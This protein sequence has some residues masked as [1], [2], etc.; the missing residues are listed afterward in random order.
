MNVKH[1]TIAIMFLCF[2]GSLKAADSGSDD[3]DFDDP[4]NDPMMEYEEKIDDPLE[5]F[6]RLMFKINNVLDK[7]ILVPISMI[8]K[9]TIPEFLQIGISN[10]T[11]NFF[12]P[13]AVINFLLQGDGEHV[14]KTTLR[15]IINTALGFF[16]AIDVASK[17]GIE[18]KTT[19]MGD[20]LKKWGAKPGPY[21]VLPLMGPGSL[22]SSV[23]KIVEMPIDPLTQTLLFT[24]PKKT[25]KKLYW[26]IYGAKIISQRASL[27]SIM[28]EIEKTS[29][30]VYAA[31]RKAVMSMEK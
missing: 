15:F 24:Y 28:M 18:K 14:A 27:L 12:S 22:R 30:D 1:V 25:R 29:E 3:W 5:P 20:T 21:V 4:I 8:Y 23:G 11:S 10:F 16:G 6:N 9:H 19:S 13:I 26:A 2:T 31:T 7:G 17:I